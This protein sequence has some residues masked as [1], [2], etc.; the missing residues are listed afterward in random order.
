MD[1]TS[2][3][4]MFLADLI[5]SFEHIKHMK[6][7]FNKINNEFDLIE[8]KQGQLEV[9]FMLSIQRPIQNEI[10]SKLYSLFYSADSDNIFNPKFG[11]NRNKTIKECVKQI[12]EIFPQE[13][14]YSIRN[15]FVAHLDSKHEK[16]K[17]KTNE[18]LSQDEIKEYFGIMNTDNINKIIPILTHILYEISTEDNKALF[19]KQQNNRNEFW[20]RYSFGITRHISINFEEDISR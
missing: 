9:D 6:N 13:L 17:P 3:L 10:V 15:R 4:K 12:K 14:L 18:I 5:G 19:K 11:L 20:K 2:G 8:K 16:H 1:N 7:I